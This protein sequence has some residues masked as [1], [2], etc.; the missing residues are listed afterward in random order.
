M[1]VLYAGDDPE[2]TTEEALAWSEVTDAACEVVA[3][4]GGHFYLET[5]REQVLARVLKAVRAAL[6]D[7]ASA[8]PSTP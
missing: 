7:T 2:V 5:H 3:F 8:W 4:T 6:P 1:T